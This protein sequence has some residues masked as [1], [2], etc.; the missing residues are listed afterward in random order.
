MIEGA[1]ETI[2]NLYRTDE[3]IYK[4]PSLHEEDSE[5]K[6]RKIIPL[7]DIYLSQEDKTEINLLDVGGGTGIILNNISNYISKRY[8]KRVNKFSLDLSPGMLEVQKRNNIDIKIALNEDIRKTSLIEK[9]IDLV[10]MIDTIEHIPDPVKALIELKRISKYIIF[11]VPLEDNL[12]LN[13]YNIVTNGK[14]RKK[15]IDDVGHINIY[16]FN[17]LRDQIEKN[18]GTILKYYYTNVFD[19]CN[20]S[21][22]YKNKTNF[23]GKIINYIGDKMYHSS[24]LLSSCIF[25]DF[26]MILVKCK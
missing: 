4:N 10:L 14:G 3:Y 9:Q 18:T 6:T 25:C 19:Y 24:P 11:K 17:R 26:V 5:W 1:D 7:V 13:I 12:E 23:I 21:D 20:K 2:T 8:G 16:N 15:A 22:I